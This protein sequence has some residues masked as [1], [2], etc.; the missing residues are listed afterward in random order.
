MSVSL[1]GT[2]NAQ[3]VRRNWWTLSGHLAKLFISVF[4]F[5]SQSQQYKSGPHF[6]TAIHHSGASFS[7]GSL[8]FW[9]VECI[10]HFLHPEKYIT[11]FQNVCVFLFAWKRSMHSGRFESAVFWNEEKLKTESLFWLNFIESFLQT[12]FYWLFFFWI[13]VFSENVWEMCN[14]QYVPVWTSCAEFKS[15]KYFH[16]QNCQVPR[17]VE[18]ICRMK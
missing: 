2:A 16:M 6:H 7:L 3:T 4:R 10:K 5:I 9:E 14:V 15:M 18:H 12:V 13:C 17:Y 8:P 11:E 1:K